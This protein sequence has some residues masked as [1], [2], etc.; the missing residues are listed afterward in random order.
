MIMFLSF[1]LKW[2]FARSLKMIQKKIHR[3]VKYHSSRMNPVD[4]RSKILNDIVFTKNGLI[5]GRKQK[6]YTPTFQGKHC[7]F[8]RGIWTLTPWDGGEG[9]FWVFTLLSI[10]ARKHRKENFPSGGVY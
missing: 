9:N 3:V 4:K 1:D 6:S 8:T 7:A 5:L 10:R 2:Y